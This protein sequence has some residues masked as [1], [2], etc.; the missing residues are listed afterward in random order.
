V[1]V[2]VVCTACSSNNAK[3]LLDQDPSIQDIRLSQLIASYGVRAHFL[4]S[5]LNERD[6]AFYGVKLQQSLSNDECLGDC[7]NVGCD[8]FNGRIMRIHISSVTFRG[9]EHVFV[10][11]FGPGKVTPD[12]FLW[13]GRSTLLT[14]RRSGTHRGLQGCEIVMLDK[15]LFAQ[16]QEATKD[17]AEDI[18]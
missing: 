14:L 13:D 9:I 6:V 4:D 11:K 3:N 7:D 18:I 1:A 12:G 2:Y 8:V 10:K 16:Q 5:A 15:E 17:K